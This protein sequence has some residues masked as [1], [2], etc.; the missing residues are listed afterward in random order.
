MIPAHSV[1]DRHVRSRRLVAIAF[2]ALAVGVALFVA[3]EPAGAQAPPATEA[4][5]E[6]LE[7]Q[8]MCP[9]CANQRLD[10]CQSA[11]CRD[12]KRIIR[13]QLEAGR[14]PDD[15]ILYFESRYGPRVRAD[16]PAEGFNLLLYGWI[17]VALVAVAAGAAWYLRSLRRRAPVPA[18]ARP[19]AT[20][21]AWLDAQLEG[22]RADR[23]GHKERP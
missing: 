20:D 14:T 11:V 17:G 18:S 1:L 15:I 4:Q 23:D 2:A 8:L 9:Q 12:M 7:R 10:T 16:L 5:A 6:A 13:E 21:D 3:L 22:P 19:P